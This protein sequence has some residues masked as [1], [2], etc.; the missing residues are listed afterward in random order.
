MKSGTAVTSQSRALKVGT[1]RG[2]EVGKSYA[3]SAKN[4]FK[5]SKAVKAGG[6]EMTAHKSDVENKN[7]SRINSS[8][9]VH[10]ACHTFSHDGSLCI[11]S[12]FF[13][14]F[15]CHTFYA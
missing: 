5:A 11:N 9:F 12:S 2:R 14:H 6:M 10:L 13:V 15:A 3:N 7:R 8:F 1:T 4:K